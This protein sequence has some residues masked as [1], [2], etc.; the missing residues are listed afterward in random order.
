M[1]RMDLNCDMGELPEAIA[2]RH[3]GI[4]DAVAD[5]GQ[6]RLRWTCGRRAHHEGNDRAGASLETGIG[7]ASWL[8]G[9]REFWPAGVES[10]AGSNR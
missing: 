6:H 10:A 8:S 3:S 1:K 7:R 2:R 4:V 9:S 5:V